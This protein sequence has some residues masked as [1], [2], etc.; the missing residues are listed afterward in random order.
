MTAP[1]VGICGG[2]FN[3]QRAPEPLPGAPG[4][5]SP[6]EG[7]ARLTQARRPPRPVARWGDQ[8]EVLFGRVVRCA[9]RQLAL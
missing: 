7:V 2:F 1:A 3:A 8:T 5:Q 4:A 6:P 9:L